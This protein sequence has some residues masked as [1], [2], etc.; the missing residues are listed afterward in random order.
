MFSDL[1]LLSKFR[2]KLLY[3][4]AGNFMLYGWVKI[5]IKGVKDTE[6]G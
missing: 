2:A 1:S 5:Q 4:K 3:L 6:S